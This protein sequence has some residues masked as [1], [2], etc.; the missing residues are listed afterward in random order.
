MST[1]SI[2]M[3]LL[4]DRM[5]TTDLD[6]AG[7]RAMGVIVR[8]AISFQEAQEI[9]AKEKVDILVIN[10]DYQKI[11]AP[12]VCKHFKAQAETK[13]LPVVITSVQTTAEARKTSLGAGADLF[14]EQ[15]V[16]RQYFIEKLKKLL[17]QKT[18]EQERVEF[19][20]DAVVVASNGTEIKAPIGDVSSTGILIS[21]ELSLATDTKVEISF[22]LPGY[23][24]PI[25]A[26]GIVAR[27]IPK[28]EGNRF[29]GIGIR[30]VDFLGDSQKRLERY[31]SKT[32]DEEARMKYYL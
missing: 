26:N 21:T 1:D 28:S 7:Y 13:E 9:V 12:L 22:S 27:S 10:Y 19:R 18:R 5:V 17:E 23:K 31:V 2:K 16:P 30:F 6:R 15:P 8:S 14:V 24:K 29:S 20:G 4:D 3:L 11:S 32:A 25:Q